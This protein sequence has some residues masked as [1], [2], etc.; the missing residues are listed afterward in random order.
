MDPVTLKVNINNAY[1]LLRIGADR[2]KT[3]EAFRYCGWEGGY[4]GFCR[5]TG[6]QP[7]EFEKA[8]ILAPEYDVQN[9]R[10][11]DPTIAFEDGG[12]FEAKEIVVIHW[13]GDMSLLEFVR[14]T[15]IHPEFSGTRVY[16]ARTVGL[17]D[18]TIGLWFGTDREFD[19]TFN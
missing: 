16:E 14:K 5:D 15:G 12:L 18:G 2:E 11:I 1:P 13:H 10:V 19:N 4:E 8:Y 9:D 6:Y 3:D 7:D 17:V